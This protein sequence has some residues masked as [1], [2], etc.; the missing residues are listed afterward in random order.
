MWGDTYPMFRR[1]VIGVSDAVILSPQFINPFRL[2]L[3]RNDL[4]IIQIEEAEHMS[5]DIEDQ[6]SFTVFEL[7]K[8]NSRISSTFIN[9]TCLFGLQ[10]YIK[11]PTCARV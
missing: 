7:G 3:E 4:K 1:L 2:A 9:Q 10:R 8:R 11:N 5:A 6:H